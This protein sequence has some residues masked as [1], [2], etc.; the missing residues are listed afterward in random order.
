MFWA[1]LNLIRLL[2]VLAV[3]WNNAPEGRDPRVR[4]R[5]RDCDGFA[6]V[7]GG[8]VRSIAGWE[9]CEDALHSPSRLSAANRI[10]VQSE[11]N[12]RRRVLA[13]VLPDGRLQFAN[14]GARAHFVSTLVALRID[15][16][17]P[18]RPARAM[19]RVTARM[20]G[21]NVFSTK[22]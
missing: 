20:L 2:A 7:E 18:Y 22:P 17:M 1:A 9:L 19:C 13:N 10:L 5:I 3:L 8:A 14:L 15:A 12:G 16:E 4:I 6:L 11:P 21:L